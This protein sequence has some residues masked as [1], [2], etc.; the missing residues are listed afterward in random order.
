MQIKNGWQRIG[1]VCACIYW[2][3][4]SMRCNEFDPDDWLT[5]AYRETLAEGKF[6]ESQA[7]L[8][9]LS[10][11]FIAI[12]SNWRIKFWRIH[13]ESPNSPKFSPAK[14]S[15]YTVVERL[16]EAFL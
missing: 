9:N 13:S 1:E 2:E 8:A 7:K 4:S 3:S 14:V 5:T 16:P 6:G 10:P 12:S 11:A 15:I